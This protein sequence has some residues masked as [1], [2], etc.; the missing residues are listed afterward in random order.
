MTTEL[1]SIRE[2]RVVLTVDDY[3]QAIRLYQEAFGLDVVKILDSQQGRGVILAAGR[4]TLE[5]V[6]R[7]LAASIDQVEVGERVSGAVRLALEFGNVDMALKSGQQAG[8][9]LLHEPV[10][11]PWNS[12]NGRL[13]AV[14]GMQLTL[15][16]PLEDDRKC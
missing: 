12:R 9:H 10:I 11:T 3:E 7:A 14:D 13:V 2:L 1:S 4:A 5:V 15:F 16:Q 6:D 8:A